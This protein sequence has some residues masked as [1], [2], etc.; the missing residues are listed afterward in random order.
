MSLSRFSILRF[1]KSVSKMGSTEEMNFRARPVLSVMEIPPSLVS[2]NRI[3]NVP[4]SFVLRRD[5]A[6]E[7]SIRPRIALENKFREKKCQNLI[8]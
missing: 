5:S 8:F 4:D 7:R 6:S 2:E 3:R 1:F